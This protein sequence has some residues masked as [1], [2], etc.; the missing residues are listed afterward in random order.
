[1]SLAPVTSHHVV[2][3]EEKKERYKVFLPAFFFFFSLSV[4]IT[5]VT[6]G[7]KEERGWRKEWGSKLHPFPL[8]ERLELY[9]TFCAVDI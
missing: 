6:K 7:E 4:F 9:H 2:G 3:R 5:C 8:G 1:M